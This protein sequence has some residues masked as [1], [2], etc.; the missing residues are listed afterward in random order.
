MKPV[1]K[2]IILSAL[3]ASVFCMVPLV[4]SAA[5]KP[6]TNADV[7][8]MLKAGLPENTIILSIQQTEA[9]FDTSPQSLILL[10]KQGVSTKV[11]D[12]MLSKQ[13]GLTSPS[14]PSTVAMSTAE[15]TGIR[16]FI[17]GKFVPMKRSKTLARS[18]AGFLG[19]GVL[20]GR[21]VLDGPSAKLRLVN[22][23]PMFELALP[24]DVDASDYITLVNLAVKEDRRQIETSRVDKTFLEG[25]VVKDGF[26]KDRV[27]AINI[28]DTGVKT[29]SGM[30][31]Y[32]VKV[33]DSIPPGEYAI[34]RAATESAGDEGLSAQKSVQANYYDFGVDTS[35]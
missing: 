32:R 8:T 22:N 6:L 20:K 35:S 11:L 24:S 34:V 10:K 15:F 21:A 25:V 4:A 27:V 29:P 18:S 23:T 3:S 1:L 28:E 33:A 5:T 17:D 12:V 13:A 31:I 19:F 30:I 14:K 26:P 9:K 7:I 16:T 2:P